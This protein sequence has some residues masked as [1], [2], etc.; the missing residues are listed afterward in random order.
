MKS[1]LR[2][3]LAAGAV[4]LLAFTGY[5][6][7]TVIDGYF[8]VQNASGAATESGYIEVTGPFTAKPTLSYEQARQSAGSIIHLTAVQE[9]KGADAVYRLT[10]LASQGIDASK[11]I[12]AATDYEQLFEDVI[13]SEG[14]KVHA[15]VRQGF[16]YG[17]TSV[18]RATVGTVFLFVASSLEKYGTE[19]PQAEAYKNIAQNFNEEVVANLDLGLRMKAVDGEQNTVQLFYDVPD[20][21]AVCD[22]YLAEDTEEHRQRKQTFDYAMLAMTE[23]LKTKHNITLETFMPEDVALLKSWGYNFDETKV[24]VNADGSITTNFATIFSDKDLLFNWIK[25]VGYYIVTPEA[26]KYNRLASLGFSDMAAKLKDHYLTKLIVENL[27]YLRPNQR[28]YLISNPA[29]DN[30]T[31]TGVNGIIDAG[32]KGKWIISPAEDITVAAKHDLE[33]KLYKSLY[34]DFPVEL[35]TD[36]ADTKLYTLGEEKIKNVKEDPANESANISY[37][38]LV[39]ISGKV[40]ALTPFIVEADMANRPEVAL[41]IPHENIFKFPLTEPVPDNSLIIGDDETTKQHAPARR[42][43]ER[44]SN[45][46]MKGVLL[47]TPLTT[48]GMHNYWDIDLTDQKPVYVFSKIAF[49]GKNHVGFKQ[50]SGSV[51]ANSAV[52]TPTKPLNQNMLLIGEP[53]LDETVGIEGVDAAEGETVIYDLNGVRVAN[54]EPGNIYIINGKKVLV[55]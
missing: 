6:Q 17:Y 48:D 21:Q 33:G 11:D 54:P 28:L 53:E 14:S 16:K 27:P 18:A 55:F 41:N 52:L 50:A 5:A 12:V 43:A 49:N 35:P 3:V 45:T 25:M 32:A 9:G 1:K 42:E 22:W 4:T 36:D 10:S 51:A 13:N 46:Q 20:L 19:G 7:E 8:R 29:G 2:N 26:D 39:E 40:N 38:E 34:F 23:W 37:T 24:T 31:A 44:T 30:L 47:A 15:L